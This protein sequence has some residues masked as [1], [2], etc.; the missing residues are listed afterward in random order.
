MDPAPLPQVI[1]ECFAS[2]TIKNNTRNPIERDGDAVAISGK[3]TS[4][5]PAGMDADG[6]EATFS[7]ECNEG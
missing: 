3:Y 1:D 2:I 5:P 4:Y 6:D 7:M